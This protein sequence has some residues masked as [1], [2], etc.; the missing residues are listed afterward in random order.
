MRNVWKGAITFGLIHIPIQLFT[1]VSDRRLNLQYLRKDDLCPIGYVKVCKM[2]GEE[3]VKEDIVKGYEYEKGDYVILENEDFARANVEKSYSIDITEFVP[4]SE[5][6]PIYYV[7]PYYIA[8]DKGAD[9]V[10]TLFMAALKRSKKVGIGKFVFKTKEHL[11]A[12]K[13]EKNE[14]VLEILRFQEEIR[15]PPQKNARKNM[16]I[17]EKELTMAIKLIDQLTDKFEPKKYKDTY[18]DELLKLIEKKATGKMP[19]KK[20]TPPKYE[21]IP[22]LME[23][24]KKSLEMSAKGRDKARK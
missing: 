2:N 12:I 1:A 23:T 7:K 19:R 3:V 10:F 20:I 14:L 13:P 24:L 4:E 18:T 6:D 8:P 15:E 16:E 17:S 22:D 9:K 5:I 21:K 11:V